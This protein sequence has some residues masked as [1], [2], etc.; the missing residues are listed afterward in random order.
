MASSGN[1]LATC[2]RHCRAAPHHRASLSQGGGEGLRLRRRQQGRRKKASMWVGGMAT[3]LHFGVS[4]SGRAQTSRCRLPTTCARC[5]APPASANA[6]TTASATDAM[7]CTCPSL[8]PAVRAGSASRIQRRNSSSATSGRPCASAA[9]ARSTNPLTSERQRT[10]GQRGV[11]VA[12]HLQRVDVGVGGHPAVAT[13][14]VSRSTTSRASP[15]RTE[16]VASCIAYSGPRVARM[17]YMP[18]STPTRTGS[19]A[20]SATPRRT[21]CV[22]PGNASRAA[23]AP[24]AS[25]IVTRAGSDSPS[26][27]LTRTRS[28][29]EPSST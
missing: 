7:A 9:W 27:P 23:S 17:R 12:A 28:D 14:R 26:S 19:L 4:R 6:S 11:A 10:I 24:S 13:S 5:G 2:L 20:A 16:T 3:P 18:G 29:A 8:A 22:D 21:A 25:T 15:A 1:P